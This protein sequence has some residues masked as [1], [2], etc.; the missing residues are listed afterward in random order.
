VPIGVLLEAPRNILY[1]QRQIPARYHVVIFAADGNY[2]TAP[3]RRIRSIRPAADGKYTLPA[4]PPGDY[5]LSAVTDIEPGEWYDPVLLDQLSR[6]ALK[7]TL[8]EGE[9]KAQD[10]RLA[11]QGR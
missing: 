4:L 5:L 1:P 11:S 6:S 10:L 8:A 3:S 7:I 2:W 9:K